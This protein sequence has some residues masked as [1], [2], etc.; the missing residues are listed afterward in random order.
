M[1]ID[2]FNECTSLSECAV[3]MFSKNNY[4]NREKIKKFLS[5]NGISNWKEWLNSH[6]IKYCQCCGKKLNER[7]L[8]YCSSSCAA[9]INNTKRKK[10]E[11][12]C[13]NCGKA[14]ARNKKYC[15][16]Q[17]QKD[18]EYK[19]NVQKWLKGEICGCDKFGQISGYVRKYLLDLHDHK[20]DICGFNETN[21]YTHYD[22]LQIHH[23]DGDC[24]NNDINNLQVLCPNH[25]AMTENYGRLNKKKKLSIIK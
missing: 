7:R 15:N 6:K 19:T 22:I 4:S 12:T 9:K 2:M 20:C 11:N 10:Q 1:D 5:D 25:H 8:K 23:I 16:I 13:Y 17:C 18:F 21:P 24:F 3:L 14:I